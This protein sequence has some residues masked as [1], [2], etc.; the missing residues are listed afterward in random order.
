MTSSLYD[1][2]APGFATVLTDMRAWP[3]EPDAALGRPVIFTRPGAP[4]PL[5]IA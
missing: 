2:S 4:E 3:D 1:A 5:A